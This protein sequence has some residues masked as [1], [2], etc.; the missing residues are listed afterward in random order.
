MKLLQL[1]ELNLKKSSGPAWTVVNP[2][3]AAAD[4]ALD[5]SSA[6]SLIKEI[7]Q[8]NS[9]FKMTGSESYKSSN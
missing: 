5:S 6:E 7:K 1:K 3:I 2:A 8:N 4:K 9:M